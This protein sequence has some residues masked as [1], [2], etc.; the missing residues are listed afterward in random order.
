MGS[1]T[2]VNDVSPSLVSQAIETRPEITVDLRRLAFTTPHNEAQPVG[3]PPAL[4]LT[5]GAPDGT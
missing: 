3:E 5:N 4:S 2:I 1:A